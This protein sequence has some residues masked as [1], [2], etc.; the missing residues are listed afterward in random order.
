MVCLSSCVY[1]ATFKLGTKLIQS[2]YVL[3]EFVF[4]TIKNYFKVFMIYDLIN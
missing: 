2:R 3:A 4:L 1:A